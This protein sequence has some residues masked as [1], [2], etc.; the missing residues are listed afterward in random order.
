MLRGNGFVI[1]PLTKEEI[2][3]LG[4]SVLEF[5]KRIGL[6]Y[7]SK[8]YSRSEIEGITSNLDMENDYW[9]LDTLWVGVDFGTK[10]VVGSLRLVRGDNKNVVIYHHNEG[11][12]TTSTK[13]DFVGL[14]QKF[15]E[16]NNYNNITLVK[17]DE[18]RYE[19]K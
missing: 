19:G 17:T 1:F 12:C 16:V 5:E 3:E 11:K 2:T 14:F 4:E 13:R 8:K 6:P 15:L 9:F 10:S 7:H 18:E